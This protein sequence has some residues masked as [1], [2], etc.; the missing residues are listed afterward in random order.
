MSSKTTNLGLTKPA[1]DEFYDVGV[2]NENM[3]IIDEKIGELESPTYTEAAQI[4]KL[5]SGEKFTIAFGKI[6]KAVSTMI[7]HIGSTS[8]PHNVTKSQVGLG[9]VP[10]VSTNNQTP[11][12]TEASS[13]TALTSGEKLSV[14][15]GKIAKAVSTLISHTGSTSNP[16]SVSKSQVGL[17]NVPNVAT[18]DQTPTYTAA[19]SLAALTSGE[20]LSIAFGKIAKAISTLI[21]HI[22][23][24]ATSSVLG[25]VKLSDSTSST[26]AASAGVAATPKAVKTAYD[27]ANK[28]SGKIGTTDISG[29]GDG[30][31][32]G[33][34]DALNQSK[35]GT[36]ILGDIKE[37][38]NDIV[39]TSKNVALDP[40]SAYLFVSWQNVSGKVNQPCEILLLTGTSTVTQVTLYGTPL[41][42]WKMLPTSGLTQGLYAKDGYYNYVKIVKL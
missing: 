32:T 1:V 11:T 18:N 36:D 8:N 15:F 9:N 16:H 20:K 13:L 29:I 33:A 31:L 35:V 4:A 41:N 42:I 19:T 34:V 38:Y 24:N 12:Y 10:N 14:A 37:V 23:A 22:S 30:T 6:A 21:G 40:N 27:L 7:S 39:T 26:S 3:D 25:H 17:G 28:S 2:Q 5:T